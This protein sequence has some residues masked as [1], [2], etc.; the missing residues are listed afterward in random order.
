M[1]RL[2]AP[3]GQSSL[4]T[5]S[6]DKLAFASSPPSS[7]ALDRDAV[8][9]EIASRAASRERD[10]RLP[11]EEIDLVRQAGLGALPVAPDRHWRNVRTIASHNPFVYKATK[12]G[13]FIVNG[14]E[15]LT[16]PCS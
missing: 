2:V 15:L 4:F 6:V 8:V 11:H 10:E 7:H 1:I 12:V 16:G 5:K 14:T 3:S 9:A 13:D